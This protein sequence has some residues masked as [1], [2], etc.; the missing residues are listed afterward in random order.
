MIAFEIAEK[1]GVEHLHLPRLIWRPVV[2]FL[3]VGVL[4]ACTST[5]EPET[6][7]IMPTATTGS[8]A[9]TT[10]TP[11]RADGQL[12]LATLVVQQGPPVAGTLLGYA[13]TNGEE[14]GTSGDAHLQGVELAA[15]QFPAGERVAIHVSSPAITAFRARIIDTHPLGG[16]A[17]HS[18]KGEG[19]LAG[20]T[21]VFTLT[22]P[23]Y[24]NGQFLRI[25]LDVAGPVP[26][27]IE[28][29]WQLI[30]GDDS[31]PIAT[32]PVAGASSPPACEIPAALPPPTATP[33]DAPTVDPFWEEILRTTSPET[34]ASQADLI[35]LGTVDGPPVSTK[36]WVLSDG[37]VAPLGIVTDTPIQVE[38]M[39]KGSLAADMVTVRTEGGCIGEDCMFVSHGAQLAPSQR[40][41]LFLWHAGVEYITL[42]AENGRY[43]VESGPDIYTIIA[44]DGMYVVSGDKATATPRHS[45]SLA[46]LLTRITKDQP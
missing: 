7:A 15:A 27:Y 10:D 1:Y 38:C 42:L 18:L 46:E 40:V 41:V 31:A 37:I 5:V 14:Y 3:V 36:S 34:L 13:L 22:Q 20:D 9:V 33:Q 17:I 30:P 35:I 25:R 4:V 45:Y 19:E 8:A 43:E 21:A 23:G 16:R 39:L 11:G 24:T 29:V 32:V 2:L 44:E 26:G 28:Y 6:D 12:P